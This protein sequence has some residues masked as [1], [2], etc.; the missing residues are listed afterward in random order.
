MQNALD[1]LAGLA[2][3][4][5]TQRIEG[6]P[7]ISPLDVPIPV[8]SDW[9]EFVNDYAASPVPL[10]RGCS[11]QVGGQANIIVSLRQLL[12]IGD[13]VHIE[14]GRGSA[15]NSPLFVSD[16][17]GGSQQRYWRQ[18]ITVISTDES[19]SAVIDP[20]S[21]GGHV[22]N[23]CRLISV[24]AETPSG[25]A[26]ASIRCGVWRRH[27][28]QADQLLTNMV[29]GSSN[30]TNGLAT[31]WFVPATAPL[32]NSGH[33]RWPV[34][35]PEFQIQADTQWHIEGSGQFGRT[36]SFFMEALAL[37]EPSS[38]AATEAKPK[39]SSVA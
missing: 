26:Q 25:D 13:A 37:Y 20:P 23:R 6:Q 28:S 39:A 27:A 1:I 14:G 34:N 7:S 30:A 2:G 16:V 18:E 5:R 35:G 8:N 11:L 22:A 9:Q 3:G 19:K 36:I 33:A 15:A 17:G 21:V 12:G 24:A 32:S 31:N 10:T 38:L 4:V 29:I